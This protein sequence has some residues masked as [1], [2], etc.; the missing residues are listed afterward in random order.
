MSTPSNAS[1]SN[2]PSARPFVAAGIAVLGLLAVFWGLFVAQQFLLAFLL[3]GGCL[4]A[5]AWVQYGALGDRVR[6]HRAVTWTVVVAVLLYA[7]LVAQ[8][9]LF[10]VL[11]ASVVYLVSWVT[12]PRGPWGEG[13]ENGR[14][15]ATD[16][17]DAE[18][19]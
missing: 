2:S 14:E 16:A 5:A 10:G 19:R 3:G 8:E 6:F 15:D 18:N 7:G 11:V 1:A 4:V 17:T 13:R 9:V 12:G